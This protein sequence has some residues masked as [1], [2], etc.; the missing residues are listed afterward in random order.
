MN[1]QEVAVH[2]SLLLV[3]PALLLMTPMATAAA[4]RIALEPAVSSGRSASAGGHDAWFRKA[5]GDILE[6]RAAG[7]ERRGR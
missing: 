2:K 4:E 3:L 1:A 5:V 6:G 7:H